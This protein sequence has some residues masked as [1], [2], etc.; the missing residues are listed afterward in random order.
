[1][2]QST[3]FRSCQAG[4]STYGK[5]PKIS[6]IKVSDKIANENSGDPDQTAPKEQSDQDL[7]CL[8][9]HLLL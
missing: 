6:N 1:M 7:H 2:A 5:C 3:L 4:Q 8:T 9:V